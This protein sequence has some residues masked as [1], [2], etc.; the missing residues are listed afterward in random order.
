[1]TIP[2]SMRENYQFIKNM[3]ITSVMDQ[4]MTPY[5]KTPM[6]DE[7]IEADRVANLADFRWYDGYFSNVRTSQL[8]PDELNFVRWKIRREVIGMWRATPGDWKF[9]KGYTYLWE[10]GF[11]HI[12]WLN[13]RLLELI[14]GIEGRYKLQMRHFLQLNDFGIRYSR[15]PARRDLS[16]HLRQQCEPLRGHSLEHAQ[17]APAVSLAQAPCRAIQASGGRTSS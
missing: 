12:V 16:S 8:T 10:F 5:P 17:A 7:M 4:I 6:R 1:M 11:R 13:E 2:K 14:F 15:P 9:F 3:G